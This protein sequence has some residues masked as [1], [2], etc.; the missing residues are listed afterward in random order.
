MRGGEPLARSTAPVVGG[1]VAAAVLAMA[2]TGDSISSTSRADERAQAE[3]PLPARRAAL[4]VG[5]GST[6]LVSRRSGHAGDAADG[7]SSAPSLSAD[8]QR[9]AFVSSARNLSGTDRD[10]V[11]DVFLRDTRR[12][13]TI[14]VSRAGGRAGAAANRHSI[15]PRISADGRYVAFESAASNLSD[16]ARAGVRNIFVRDLRRRTTT[17][18]SRATGPRGA[19]AGADATG[20]SISRGGRR[21]AFESPASNLT[22]ADDDTAV[23]RYDVFVRDLRS[24]RTQLV[25]RASGVRGRAASASAQAMISADGRYVAFDSG[26][27]NLTREGNDAILEVY[28]RDLRRHR[29]LLASRASGRRGA[30]ARGTASH[31]SISADGRYVAFE[32]PAG[33]LSPDDQRGFDVFVRDMRRGRTVLGTRAGGSRGAGADAAPECFSV[34][35]RGDDLAFESPARNLSPDDRDETT[36]VFLRGLGRGTTT[37]V[38]RA[39]GRDGPAADADSGCPSMSADA[40]W[41]AF[42]SFATNRSPVDRA[43]SQD[44]FLRRP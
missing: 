27:D 33:N 35:S 1:A 36:D 16:G 38:S 24:G 30:P 32:S 10:G 2:A 20:P 39:D 25:S 4:R 14:L 5:S 37:L 40:A 9:V 29:T 44:V 34:S 7:S 11:R 42:E 19:G 18:A 23:N 12:G 3:R 31:P 22:H 15:R 41:V 26:A 13:V 17:L 28:V 6:V 21:V 43:A 8:G